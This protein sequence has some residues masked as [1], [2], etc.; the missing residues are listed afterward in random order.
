MVTN[1][2]LTATRPASSLRKVERTGN[3]RASRPTQCEQSPYP[4]RIAGYLFN[5]TGLEA[6]NI[7]SGHMLVGRRRLE[8]RS[9]GLQK[10]QISFLAKAAACGLRPPSGAFKTHRV[11]HVDRSTTYACYV[12]DATIA[13]MVRIISGPTGIA[14]IAHKLQIWVRGA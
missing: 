5:R 3:S 6:N 14:P 10:G 9:S 7:L 13:R 4:N 2:G 8:R 12:K 1:S 11:R